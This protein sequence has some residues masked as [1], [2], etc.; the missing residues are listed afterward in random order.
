[1][2]EMYPAFLDSKLWLKMNTPVG[3]LANMSALELA[4]EPMPVAKMASHTKPS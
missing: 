3:R 4:D 2:R 1:M